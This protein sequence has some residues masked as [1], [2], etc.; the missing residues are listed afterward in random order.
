[1]AWIITHIPQDEDELGRLLEKWGMTVAFDFLSE[2]TSLVFIISIE[3]LAQ[4]GEMAV[5][6][7]DALY[8]HTGR[9]NQTLANN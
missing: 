9:P 6:R 5:V 1:M 3:Y 7:H 2:I 8:H 4:T